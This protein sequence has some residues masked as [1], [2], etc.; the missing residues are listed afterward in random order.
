MR[1]PPVVAPMLMG[2]GRPPWQEAILRPLG[3]LLRDPR[4]A[5][6]IDLFTDP[7]KDALRVFFFKGSFKGSLTI[8][9]L[10]GSPPALPPTTLTVPMILGD[11]S[12]TLLKF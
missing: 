4:S 8:R 9:T 7:F 3:V 10:R 1:P 2:A 6:P 11:A 5:P 12:N